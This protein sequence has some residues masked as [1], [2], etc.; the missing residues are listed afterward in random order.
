MGLGLFL[1]VA[2]ASPELKL[3]ALFQDHAVFQQGK[4][5]PVWGW[6][7]PGQKVEVEYRGNKAGVLTGTSGRWQVFLPAMKGSAEP[8]ELVVRAEK[9]IVLHD[10]VVGEVW[11]C[12]GQSNMEWHVRDVIHA[13]QEIAEAD[14]PLIRHFR[15][16]LVVSETPL[17][18]CAGAWTPASPSTVP[19]FSAVAYFFAR[20][21]HRNLKVPIGLIN[22]SWGGKM[23]E[24]FMSEE[25]L[26]GSPASE[27]V[28]KRWKEQQERFPAVLAAHEKQQA[29]SSGKRTDPRELFAQNRPSS[30]FNG[31]ISPVIPYAIRGAIWYQGEHNIGRASEYNGLFTAMIADWR[32]KFQQGDFPFYFVQLANFEAPLDKS[33]EGY[34]KLR[35]AQLQTLS[36]P[37]SGMAVTI[38]IGTPE[39]VHPKNKQE[40]GAR[41]AR[42][43]Q[44]KTYNLGGVWSG[45]LFKSAIRE[46]S[47]LRLTFDHAEGGL[48]APHEPITSFEV[49]GASGKFY[50]ATAKIDGRTLV[51]QAS[52]VKEPVSVRY[53]WANAPVASLFNKEGL[54]ASPFRTD[55][56][57]VSGGH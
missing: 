14:F 19:A 2:W 28:S 13:E 12:S 11:L 17:A 39:N 52:E 51:V 24:V 33:R 22:T 45:P 57:P 16:S 42:W 55:N 49:A 10:V 41:L 56:S 3:G 8:A 6:A 26:A 9:S 5:V 48:V 18:D 29:T 37:N 43:A 50:P 35:E 36:V 40:V 7:V 20:D 47:S 4:P 38:D 32:Q 46:A 34:A 25:A 44:A 15:T 30:L 21:L 1:P 54:P 53:A 23:I 27:A 31:M